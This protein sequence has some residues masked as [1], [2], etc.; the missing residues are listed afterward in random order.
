MRSS[1]VGIELTYGPVSK[2]ITFANTAAGSPAMFTLTG[3]VWVRIIAVTKTDL[4]SAAAA[5]VELGIAGTTDAILPTTVATALD[6]EEQWVDNSP[7]S[8]IEAAGDAFLDYVITGGNDILLTLD[9]QV[10]TGAIQFYAFWR[11]LSDGSSVV[12]A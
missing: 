12:A 9:T 3:D 10:D 2:L 1:K 4:T 11:P 6:A 8:E 5:N 7:D